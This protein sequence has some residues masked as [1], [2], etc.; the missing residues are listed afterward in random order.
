MKSVGETN[1][2]GFTD[3]LYPSVNQSSVMSHV[4]DVAAIVHPQK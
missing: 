2:D 1:T 4:S 3:G